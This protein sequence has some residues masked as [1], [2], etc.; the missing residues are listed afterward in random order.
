VTSD[1]DVESDG[2]VVWI[3]GATGCVARFGANGIDIHTRDTTACLHC[4]H[5]P[6]TAED[7][8]IFQGKML[9]HYRL[10]IGDEHRPTRFQESTS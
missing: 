3:N 4:T 8:R 6:T 2:R 9:E 1:L 5:G 7:W 10:V